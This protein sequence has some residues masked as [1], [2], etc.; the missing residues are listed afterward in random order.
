MESKISLAIDCRMYNV[1]GIGT[2]LKNVLAGLIASDRYLITC[3]GYEELRKESWFNRVTFIPLKS[4][5]LHP[6]EQLEIYRKVPK[7]DIYFTPHFNTPWIKP[8]RVKKLVSTIHDVYHLANPEKYSKFL[9][10]YIRLLVWFT[11]RNASK[12]I[13]VSNF[14]RKEIIRFFPRAEEKLV[15]SHLGVT[16]DFDNGTTTATDG[17]YLLYVGNVKPHKNID[18]VIKALPLLKDKDVRLII[19]GKKEGFYSQYAN[20]DALIAT[21]KDRVIFTGYVDDKLLKQYYRNAALFVFPS[22]YEGFGLPVLEAMKFKIP[23]IASEAASIPEV[24]GDAIH[25]FNPGNVEEIAGMIDDV[26]A[27][28]LSFDYNRYDAQLRRFDW[29]K[30][31]ETHLNILK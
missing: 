9:L 26:L 19:I 25:Y 11:V 17:K 10:S 21:L 23:I 22:K 8:R 14:S 6:S 13:T 20:T 30:T 18:A 28:K 5:V 27:G 1:S 24:G 29:A 2:Y 3:L 31:I 12:I 7:C 4:R 15:V 16:S